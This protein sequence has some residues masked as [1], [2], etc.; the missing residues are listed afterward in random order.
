MLI[1][2][3]LEKKVTPWIK[4]GFNSRLAIAD[5][6]G[7]VA[8]PEGARVSPRPLPA[9]TIAEPKRYI[10]G[11]IEQVIDSWPEAALVSKRVPLLMGV[12]DGAADFQAG[13]NVVHCREGHFLFLQPGVPHPN[14]WHPH[15][16]PENRAEGHCDLLWFTPWKRGVR[17]W[18]CRSRGEEHFYFRTPANNIF[19]VDERAA[20]LF[21]MLRMELEAGSRRNAEVCDGLMGV[22]ATSLLHNIRQ[23]HVFSAELE[24][25]RSTEIDLDPIQQVQDMFRANIGK[26]LTLEQ[27]A[28]SVFMSRAQFAR[29]FKAQVGQTFAVWCNECRLRH[30]DDLL[31][32][33]DVPVTT[34]CRFVGIKSPAHFHQL[35]R[36]WAGMTPQKYREMSYVPRSSVN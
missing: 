10:R 34:I 24:L 12:L 32:E 9:R 22:I 33:T 31:R 26:P 19:V 11:D 7:I 20:Q 36:Q 16:D 18:T 13:P 1:Q 21:W 23:G 25:E 29:K 5:E 14:G 8:L 15:L 3:L 6:Q 35:F 17:L 2:D 4:S 28:H 27:A 30:A